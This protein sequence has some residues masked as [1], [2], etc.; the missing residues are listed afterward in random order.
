MPD[1]EVKNWKEYKEYA[2]YGERFAEMQSQQGNKPAQPQAKQSGPPPAGATVGSPM[3]IASQMSFITP[4]AEGPQADPK[5][6]QS[7]DEKAGTGN[8]TGRPQSEQ[9]AKQETLSSIDEK[10][11]LKTVSDPNLLAN[12]P[13]GTGDENGVATGEDMEKSRT[14]PGH[15]DYSEAV[16]LNLNSSSQSRRRRRRATTIGSKRDPHG[17]DEYLDKGR[18]EDLLNNTQGH[19]ILWPYDWYVSTFASIGPEDISTNESHPGS[20]KRN[21]VETGS[22]LWTRFLL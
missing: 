10:A 7:I 2:T 14:T 8:E 9:L 3:S 15:V 5:S 13:N 20:R 11:A 4:R 22:T 21:K 18:A 17:A 1:S 16:N 19:L 6:P 12:V